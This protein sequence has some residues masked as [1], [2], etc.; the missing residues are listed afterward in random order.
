[1]PSALP[2]MGEVA[3]AAAALAGF[4]LVF[5]GGIFA[6]FD[7]YERTEKKS[8]LPRFQRRAWFGFVGFVLALAST[9]LALVAKWLTNE[10]T[11]AVALVLL[12]IALIWVLYATLSD[13]R[14]VS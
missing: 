7:S 11:A 4:I 14:E 2:V 8:V 1:M 13:V 10:C 5:L 12:F 3:G 9:F 6:S